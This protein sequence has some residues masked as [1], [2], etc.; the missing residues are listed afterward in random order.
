MTA[1]QRLSLRH[2]LP[3]PIALTAKTMTKSTHGT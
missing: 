2:L 1:T 3:G